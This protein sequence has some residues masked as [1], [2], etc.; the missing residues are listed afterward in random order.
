MTAYVVT[1][2]KTYRIEAD[3]IDDAID[4]C[5]VATTNPADMEGIEFLDSSYVADNEENL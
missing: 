3:T 4:V 5:K 2:V 1:A